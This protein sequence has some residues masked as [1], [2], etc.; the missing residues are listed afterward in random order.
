MQALKQVQVT[1]KALAGVG[2]GAFLALVAFLGRGSL[3]LTAGPITSVAVAAA[4]AAAF[5]Q[6]RKL[7]AQFIFTDWVN[8]EK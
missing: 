2:I 1:Q 5:V 6:L 8:H 3:L 4:C 7:E